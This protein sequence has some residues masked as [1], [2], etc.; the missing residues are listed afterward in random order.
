MTDQSNEIP[1]EQD[2]RTLLRVVSACT[3]GLW[4][5]RSRFGDRSLSIFV[6]EGLPLRSIFWRAPGRARLDVSID[7]LHNADPCEH[8]RAAFLRDQQQRFDCIVTSRRLLYFGWQHAAA[9]E[10]DRGRRTRWTNR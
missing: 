3:L 2:L 6:I 9:G 7:R 1:Q 10:H 5:F 4:A 8:G